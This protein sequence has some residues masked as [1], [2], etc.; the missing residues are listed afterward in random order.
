MSPPEHAAKLLPSRPEWTRCECDDSFRCIPHD[1]CLIH[2]SCLCDESATFTPR[3]RG[4]Y[5]SRYRSYLNYLRGRGVRY[6]P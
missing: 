2:E 5:L 1:A 6:R 4:G 3:P